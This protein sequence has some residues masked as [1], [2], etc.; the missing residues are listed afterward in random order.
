MS[1]R[2]VSTVCRMSDVGQLGVC[3]NTD[4][5]IADTSTLGVRKEPLR[6]GTHWKETRASMPFYAVSKLPPEPLL[7]AFS[8]S[9]LLHCM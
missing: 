8:T 3:E 1:T 6:R 2:Q 7:F 4:Y 9:V 5:L